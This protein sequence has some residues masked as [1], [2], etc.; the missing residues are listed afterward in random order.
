[1]CATIFIHRNGVY[2]AVICRKILKWFSES[3]SIFPFRTPVGSLPFDNR[4][5]AAE[6]QKVPI[7]SSPFLSLPS[8]DTEK[9]VLCSLF[10]G[11]ATRFTCTFRFSWRC[12]I[13]Y[14]MILF[15]ELFFVF[16]VL[17]YYKCYPAGWSTQVHCIQFLSPSVS[18]R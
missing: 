7:I 16:G 1:M 15:E 10:I 8:V 3:T 11:I 18:V 14:P 6:W 4:P 12:I 13:L 2:V 17:R 9:T 5:F